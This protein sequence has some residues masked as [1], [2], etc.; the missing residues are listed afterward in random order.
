MA[1]KGPVN[2]SPFDGGMNWKDVFN[3]ARGSTGY[4]GPGKDIMY[5]A[6]P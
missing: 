3:K 5:V 6:T 4:A 2:K 1:D